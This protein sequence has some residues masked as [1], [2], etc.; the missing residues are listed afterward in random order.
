MSTHKVSKNAKKS[1]SR[2]HLGPKNPNDARY[3]QKEEAIRRVLEQALAE[4]KVYL[5]VSELCRQ[6]KM[7]PTTFYSHYRSIDH[8]LHAY[9]AELLADLKRAVAK[10]KTHR[11]VVFM[12]LLNFVREHLSYFKATLPVHNDWLT[13]KMLESLCPR[14]GLSIWDKNYR[15]YVHLWCSL[16]RCWVIFEDPASKERLALYAHKMARMKVADGQIVG[17]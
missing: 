10:V 8:A 5:S 1:V 4:R 17:I 2:L 9:E 6:A 11:E 15:G 16:V 12:I 7:A 14:L 3:R 13:L